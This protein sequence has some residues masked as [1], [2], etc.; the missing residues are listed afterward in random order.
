MKIEKFFHTENIFYVDEKQEDETITSVTDNI[1]GVILVYS[2]NTNITHIEYKKLLN[3]SYKAEI[4]TNKE[5]KHVLYVYYVSGK[6]VKLYDEDA[7]EFLKDF[8]G[9]LNND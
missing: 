1:E 2:N 6:L 8:L 3:E 5:F 4:E 7:D 9:W